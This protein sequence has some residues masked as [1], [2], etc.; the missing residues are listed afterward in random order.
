MV[1]S[2]Q[3]RVPHFPPRTMFDVHM[4]MWGKLFPKSGPLEW[5]CTLVHREVCDFLARKENP[6]LDV[7]QYADVGMD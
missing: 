2:T 7:V 3:T 4:C 5:P 6:I 1:H